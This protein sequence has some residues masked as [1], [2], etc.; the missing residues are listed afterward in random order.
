MVTMQ[1]NGQQMINY[2]DMGIPYV[3]PTHMGDHVNL[4]SSTM[5]QLLQV[6]M[7]S[8]VAASVYHT[9]LALMDHNRQAITSRKAL[10]KWLEVSKKTITSAICVLQQSN[11]IEVSKHNGQNVYTL[12]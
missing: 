11:L 10:A 1:Q 4:H 5:N 6:S 12:V 3:P 7:K 8:I 9:L 2:P